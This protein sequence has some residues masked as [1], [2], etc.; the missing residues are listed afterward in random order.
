M[1]QRIWSVWVLS[2]SGTLKNPRSELPGFEMT[3]FIHERYGIILH[4][5]R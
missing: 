1:I 2:S 4:G 5:L 3:T